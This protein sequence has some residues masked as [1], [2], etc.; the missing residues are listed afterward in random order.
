M[1][2]TAFYQKF[3]NTEFGIVF[4]F[5]TGISFNILLCWW[6]CKIGD[7]QKTNS[8]DIGS[9]SSDVSSESSSSG[10]GAVAVSAQFF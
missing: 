1:D 3:I 10:A 2:D 7:K 4:L 6:F 9:G 8:H 5:V